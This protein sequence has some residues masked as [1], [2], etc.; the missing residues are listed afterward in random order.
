VRR[1]HACAAHPRMNREQWEAICREAWSLYYL[2]HCEA[3]GNAAAPRGG[4]RSAG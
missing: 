1:E 4:N 3:Y 2:L